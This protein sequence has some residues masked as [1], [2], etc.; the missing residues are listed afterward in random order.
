MVVAAA[1]GLQ[2]VL[3]HT[4]ILTHCLLNVGHVLL[5]LL[6]VGGGGGGVGGGGSIFPRIIVFML[7]NLIR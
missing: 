1:N 5:F 7:F 6:F 3:H 4:N 2:F